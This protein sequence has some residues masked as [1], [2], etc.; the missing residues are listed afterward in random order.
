MEA[1]RARSR[2][3]IALALAIALL[4][5]AVFAP[6]LAGGFVHDDHRQI[7]HNPLV[8]DLR[9]LPALWTSGVWAGGGSASSWYRPLM[10]SSFALDRALLGPAPLAMHGVSLALH[11]ALAA[12]VFAAARALGAARASALGAA[13][14]GAAHPVQAEAV[15]WISA[16]CELLLAVCALVAFSCHDRALAAA[17]PRRRRLLAAGAGLAFFLSLAAKESALA[18]APLFFCIDRIRGAGARPR[19]LAARHAP[20]VAALLAY[21]A[22]RS[23][24]LGG[25]SGGAVAPVAPAALLG[26]LGQG[27][28]RLVAPH[29]L[30]ISPPPPSAAHAAIGTA[31]LAAGVVALAFA[32]RRRSPL[33]APLAAGLAMLAI[34]AFGAARLGE[35]ADRYLVLPAFAAAWLAAA[36]VESLSGAARAAGR[37]ALALA[38]VALA[39]AAHAHVSV[40]ASD[41]ALWRDAWDKNPRSLRAALNMSAVELDR[42][43]P[44]TALAWL[45]RAAALAP[46]DPDVELNRAV[47]EQQLGNTTAAR[48]RLEA[49]AGARPELWPAALRAGHLALD[50]REWDAAALRYESVLRVHPL[51][52]EAWAGLA[53]ARERQGRRDEALRAIDRALALDPRVENADALHALRA[54]LA[55]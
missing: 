45:E 13:A 15:A 49:L 52:A 21:F 4:A 7:A 12:L 40:Y 17:D 18:L 30:T 26:A 51:A 16:R 42:G 2:R 38:G 11:G 43:E 53:V 34:A 9:H 27:A 25:P 54:R 37:A 5:I 47:A 29:A 39:V 41:A 48:A 8:Q 20:W 3:D 22:L 44:R 14:L 55:R 19:A 35:L 10:T 1:A 33:L 46:G 23:L 6:A 50:A 32:W 31:V 24:A 28:A 36:A